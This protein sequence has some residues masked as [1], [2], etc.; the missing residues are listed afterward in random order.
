MAD[1]FNQLGR[2]LGSAE[3]QVAK[4]IGQVVGFSHRQGE[5]VPIW[6]QVLDQEH[7]SLYSSTGRL[8]QTASTTFF[9]PAQPPAWSGVSGFSGAVG[10]SACSGVGKA[11]TTGDRIEWPIGSGRYFWVDEP[12]RTTHNGFVYEV[13]ATEIKTLAGG[14]K[15]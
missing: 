9:I 5:P 14:A 2:D 1:F 4:A 6:A 7:D 12:I 15:A 10:I 13:V 11:I 3:L 8:S